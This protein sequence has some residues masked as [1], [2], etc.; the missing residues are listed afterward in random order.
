MVE[1]TFFYQHRPHF[2][3]SHAKA[4]AL[5]KAAKAQLITCDVVPHL[6][7]WPSEEAPVDV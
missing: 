5:A 2:F 4:Y 3:E 1:S 6:R 7:S